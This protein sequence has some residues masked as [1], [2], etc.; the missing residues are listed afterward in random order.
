MD[1]FHLPPDQWCSESTL[2]GDEAHHCRRV[3]RKRVG[4]LIE[5]F[6]GAGALAKAEITALSGSGVSLNL[7]SPSQSDPLLPQLEIAVG[8]PKGK[9]FDLVIQKAVELGVN[10]IQPLVTAQ[11]NVRFKG[12]EGIAKK[13]KWQ[14]LALEAC[15]Q[16]GQNFLPEVAAPVELCQWLPTLS[17]EEKFVGALTPGSKPLR[18][19]LAPLSAP[20]KVI[21]LIGPEGDFSAAEYESISQASFSPVSLGDLVL[22]TETAVMAMIAAVRYQFQK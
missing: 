21:F 6:D 1:R 11:G 12:E 15:K 10:R 5:V 7:S 16:C 19:W 14:R 2:T 13:E 3:M 8:I 18:E 20:E 4:D 9:S 17:A 22:R